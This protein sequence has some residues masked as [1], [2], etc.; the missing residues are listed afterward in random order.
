MKLSFDTIL[1]SILGEKSNNKNLDNSQAMEDMKSYD[2]VEEDTY[3]QKALYFAKKEDIGRVSKDNPGQ[4]FNAGH[5]DSMVSVANEA[6]QKGLLD[7]KGADLFIANQMREARRDFGV[8]PDQREINLTEGRTRDALKAFFP[9]E[10]F[11]NLKQGDATKLLASYMHGRDPDPYILLKPSTASGIPH[12]ITFKAVGNDVYGNEDANS[13]YRSNKFKDHQ[14]QVSYNDYMING[15][16]AMIKFLSNYDKETTHEEAI[17]RWNKDPKHSQQ[18]FENLQTLKDP[19]NKEIYDYIESR[20][21]YT[22]VK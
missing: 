1:T 14:D 16:I 2:L 3:N 7:P 6:V 12:K 4:K 8:R 20:K 11:D 22:K 9:N 10:N 5:I 19:H 13:P 15:K 18:V 17:K 21:N